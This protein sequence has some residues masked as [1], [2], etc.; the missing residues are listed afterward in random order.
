MITQLLVADS[1]ACVLDRC[2]SYFTN[3]GYQVAAAADAL[4]C[5]DS[6][7]RIPP[8]IMVVERELP[9]G[10]GEGVLVCLREDDFRWP[11][12]VIVT[13]SEL[14]G[15]LPPRL[16]PPVKAVLRRPY[17]LGTLFETIR[18][19]QYGETQL[20]ARFLRNAQQVAARER[21][22]REWGWAFEPPRFRG[23]V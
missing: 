7:R 18:R 15:D 19:A 11:Q 8:D 10:G 5:L 17:S 4:E 13:T 1:D 16:D 6:L 22:Q 3:R 20:A 9:W 12:T 14:A 23:G 2:R 21:R